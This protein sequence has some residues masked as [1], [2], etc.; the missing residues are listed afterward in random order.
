[1][2]SLTSHFPAWGLWAAGSVR[3]ENA[4]SRLVRVIGRHQ[5]EPPAEPALRLSAPPRPAE[6]DGAVR[7]LYDSS[8][9]FSAYIDEE[10]LRNLLDD[11]ETG[12]R[13]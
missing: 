3:L 7:P 11:E 1:M 5:A 6:E 8:A 2:K 4:R 12:E 13:L 9:Y 10:L